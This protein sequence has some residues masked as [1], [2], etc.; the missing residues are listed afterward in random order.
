MFEEDKQNLKEFRKTYCDTGKK[1]LSKHFF[2][3]YFQCKR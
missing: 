1:P 2:V 3:I